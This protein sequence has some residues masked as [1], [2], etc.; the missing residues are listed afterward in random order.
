MRVIFRYGYMDGKVLEIS[1][2]KTTVDII[3][4]DEEYLGSL[5]GLVERYQINKHL[6]GSFTAILV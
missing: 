6:D 5:R 4:T 2:Q 1:D 3:V